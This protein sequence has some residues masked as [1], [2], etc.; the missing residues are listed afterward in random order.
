MCLY[1]KYIENPKY[2]PNKKNDFNPP[3]CKDKR[4]LYVPVKCNRCIECRTQKQREWV[5]RLSEEIRTEKPIFVTLTISPEYMQKKDA[6][7]LA[8]ELHRMF[9]ERIRRKTG[10]SVKHWAITELGENRG[11]IH[12]HGLY[13]CDS[14]LITEKW[15]YGH[16]YVGQFVNEKTIRYI[17]KYMLKKN[18]YDPLFQGVILSSSGIG[19][20]Y[21]NRFDA[22]Q[23]RYKPNG[24]T[25]ETYKCRDGKISTLPQYYRLKLYSEEEREKLW[26][27]KQE[28]EY[29]FIMG[30]KVEMN[31]LETWERLTERWQ[32][33]GKDLY[34]DNVDDWNKEK[35]KKR[36]IRMRKYRQKMIKHMLKTRKNGE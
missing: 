13:W 4:L 14:E 12:L 18:P 17:T 26:I 15:Q 2:K 34:N 31:D 29:R 8:T 23:N 19:K 11:R 35:Q 9:L 30:T 10:K 3:K 22:W 27:E 20:N 21:L 32:Q 28:R 6:N 1:T 24:Q 33:I 16:V 25:D 36:L 5:T 7:T